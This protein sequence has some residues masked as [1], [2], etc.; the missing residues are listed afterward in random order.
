MTTAIRRHVRDEAAPADLPSRNA[1]SRIPTVCPFDKHQC[2]GGAN[3]VIAVLTI[4]AG[5][6][7]T[8]ASAQPAAT[9]ATFSAD[10]GGRLLNRKGAPWPART[11]RLLHGRAQY[12]APM[13]SGASADFLRS[14]R[15]IGV[16]RHLLHASRANRRRPLDGRPFRCHTT[17]NNANE[18]G[19][20]GDLP[21]ARCSFGRKAQVAYR[22]VNRR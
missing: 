11:N 8:P 7:A 21:H 20:H 3:E 19:S 16:V 9:P 4:A 6:S 1:A 5:L 22:M 12:A 17:R 10:A 14:G 2:N 13:M 15:T 18:G